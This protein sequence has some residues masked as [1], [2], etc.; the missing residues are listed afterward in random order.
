MISALLQ[1]D[2]ETA[3]TL[4]ASDAD[5]WGLAWGALTVGAGLVRGHAAMCKRDP[6]EMWSSA[7]LKSERGTAPS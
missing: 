6:L 5:P 4:I 2:T 7:L 1:E 3:R